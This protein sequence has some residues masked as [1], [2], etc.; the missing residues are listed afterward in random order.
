MEM[1]Y[2]ATAGNTDT[3]KLYEIPHITESFAEYRY[4][5][6]LLATVYEKRG[7]GRGRG[8]SP[9]PKAFNV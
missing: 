8:R 4:I 1:R 5:C 7:R 2:P 9:P 3:A 6:C